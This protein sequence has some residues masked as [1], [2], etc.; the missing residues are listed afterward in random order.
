MV[1]SSLPF[2][3]VFLPVVF[4]AVLAIP[5]MFAKNL[6]LAVASLV[7]YAY[8]EPVYVALLLASTL[9][10]W[11]FGLAIWRLGAG[12]SG[13]S[14][15]HA[16]GQEGASR[17][18]PSDASRV[19]VTVAIVCN[20]VFLG[21]FKYSGMLIDTINALAGTSFAAPDV[22]LPI[23]ISFYTFQAMSYVVDVYRGEV[24]AQRSFLKVL[25]Y[26]SFFPQL[27]AGP[28]VKYHDV[29][30]QLDERTV[31]LDGVARGFRR[32]CFGLAKKVLI[33]NVM[34]VVVDSIFSAVESE[35]NILNAWT[36][37]IAYVMQ[38]YFD[39]GGYS[40]MAIGLASMFG[41]TYPE[42]FNYP[43]ASTTVKEFWRRWHISLSTWLKE[44]LYIPLGGNRKGRARTVVNKLIVFL[45]CG[46]WHG[47][48]WTY[49]VWGLIHG[50]FLLLEE[51]VPL[52]K[53]PKPLGW[54][55][56]MLVVTFSFVL[57]RSESFD[58][59]LFMMGQMLTGTDFTAESMSLLMQQLTPLFVFTLIVAFVAAMPIKPA[60]E[61]RVAG[62]SAGAV[63]DSLGYVFALVLLV[64]CLLSLASGGYNAFIYFQF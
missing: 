42:N 4:L 36:G 62:T 17:Y 5:G 18:A 19:A 9:V 6:L 1:F 40:D 24:S 22:E 34:G 55:Y 11:L 29:E 49:V 12:R 8:D 31:T 38:I 51:Y 10:N 59:G 47:A 23:G 3:C 21:F 63:C 43:Y 48:A 53:L 16:W 41:F 37:A 30:E 39:F 25:L 28:I 20:L 2:I 33:S 64:L 56:T 32:F 45:C 58:Q 52:R 14:G 27:V 13:S 46:L 35:I 54:F 60:I 61:R 57:F 26:V 15:Q 50:L 44:Y 7:F